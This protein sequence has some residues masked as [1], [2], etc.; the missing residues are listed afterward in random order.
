MIEQF[1]SIEIAHHEAEFGKIDDNSGG[2][3]LFDE[4][5][6]WALVKILEGED[7]AWV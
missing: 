4:F 2:E 1:F 5:S 7:K 6:H 3:L